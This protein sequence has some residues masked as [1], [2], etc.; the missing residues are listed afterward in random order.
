MSETN[1]EIEEALRK[2]AQRDFSN[3]L[4]LPNSICLEDVT[5]QF[6]LE[7]DWRGIGR[8]G[9][10]QREATYVNITIKGFERQVQVWLN[11]NRIVLMDVEYPTLPSELAVL[12]NQIGEPE[13]KLDAY[14]G[15]FQ[16]EQSEWV[17]PSLGLTLF[18]NPEN[19]I[20]LRLAVFV[21][22]TLDDYLQHLRLNLQTRRF[23]WGK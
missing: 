6:L 22:S 9:L 7:D 21:P 11:G 23:P 17:Y 5:H 20:I 2:F 12:L 4:G 18:V 15:V 14:L 3:W 10:A 19:Y 13:A 1:I 8:L 16:L